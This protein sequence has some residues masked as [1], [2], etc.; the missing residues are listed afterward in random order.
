MQHYLSLTYT[1][2]E[3]LIRTAY[4][5]VLEGSSQRRC[6][7][8]SDLTFLMQKAGVATVGSNVTVNQFMKFYFDWYIKILHCLSATDLWPFE[9]FISG[10]VNKFNMRDALLSLP[11]IESSKVLIII[12]Y[13]LSIS[14]TI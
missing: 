12:F 3:H 8:E 14:L 2:V 11:R 7:T 10:F 4:S 13:V 1:D 5:E 6:I 9:E